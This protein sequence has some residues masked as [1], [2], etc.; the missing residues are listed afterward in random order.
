MP[1]RPQRPW[2]TLVSGPP[3]PVVLWSFCHQIPR[4]LLC[5]WCVVG[6]NEGLSLCRNQRD[7]CFSLG[8]LIVEQYSIVYLYRHTHTHTH[9]HTYIFHY[10]FI[11]SSFDRHLCCFR[12]HVLATVN[13]DA[14]NIGMHIP[15]PISCSKKKS[16]RNP[17]N[18]E[19]KDF[20]WQKYFV[21][22]PWVRGPDLVPFEIGSSMQRGWRVSGEKHPHLTGPQLLKAQGRPPVGILVHEN[23][24]NISPSRC[25]R[26]IHVFQ[27][28]SSGSCLFPKPLSQFPR[29]EKCKVF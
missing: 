18:G 11:Y 1:R 19:N 3:S 16:R 12:F 8:S 10:F 23:G 4:S 26:E 29:P 28:W 13:N 5:F 14:M 17:L 9:T 7:N 15:F 24:L 22:L 27:D 21:G 25:R 6:A 2:F 20:K